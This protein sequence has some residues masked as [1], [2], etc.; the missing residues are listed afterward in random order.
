MDF[1]IS[2]IIILILIF[3]IPISIVLGIYFIINN[4]VKKS[5]AIKKENNLLL[6]EMIELLKKKQEG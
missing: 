3:L 4:W 5:N 2:E 1:V 6:R